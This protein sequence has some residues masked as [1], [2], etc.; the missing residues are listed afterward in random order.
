[1]KKV[2]KKIIKKSDGSWDTSD[3]YRNTTK[4]PF[5]IEW[6]KY[7]NPREGK[8]QVMFLYTSKETGDIVKYRF[9]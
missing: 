1:M 8:D 7:H 3:L 5:N 2:K 4:F 9:L 6:L